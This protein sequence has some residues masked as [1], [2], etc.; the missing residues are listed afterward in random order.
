M[1][2]TVWKFVVRPERVD[3]FERHYGPDGTWAALFRK[4]PGYVRTE[5]F[6]GDH[7][8]YITIDYWEN[9]DAYRDFRE[10]CVAEYDAL[11][12]EMQGLTER[13]EAIASLSQPSNSATQQLSNPNT[14][15]PA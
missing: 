7:H 6:R 12:A 2:V 5:L 4:A 3:E 14:M 1:F 11:D 15:P 8:E 13:E 9:A 10:R